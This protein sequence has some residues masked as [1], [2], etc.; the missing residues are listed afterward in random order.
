[1]LISKENITSIIPHRDPV[2]MIDHLLFQ[3]EK[4]TRT[5][6]KIEPNN[7]FVSNSKF[8]EAGIIENI[9]QSSAA[10]SGYYYLQ[11]KKSQPLTFIASISNLQILKNAS[12]GEE[13]FTEIELMDSVMNFNIICGKC[14]LD[15]I[16]IASCEM[17]VMIENN[18]I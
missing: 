9:A 8:T 17:K 5:S 1:M 6:F 18:Q 11:N 16:L 3:D 7:I 15:D 13:I 12:A 14:F 4:Y 10:G 2:L